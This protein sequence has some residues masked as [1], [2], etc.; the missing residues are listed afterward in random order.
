MRFHHAFV[1][2]VLC[3][4][5]ALPLSANTCPFGIL[6]PTPY[7][8]NDK[9]GDVTTG[10][11]N[12]D[13]YVDAAV[14]NRTTGQISILLGTAGG[15]FAAPTVIPTDYSQDDILAADFNHDGNLDLVF[16]V[17]W[18]NNFT[19]QPHLQMLIGHGDGTF[20]AQ[21]NQQEIFQNPSRMVLG[22][23]NKD[24]WIDVATT[25]ADGQWS[26]VQNVNGTLLQKAEY[27]TAG[28]IAAGIA[29][30]DFDGDGNL[31]I[32]ISEI[33]SKKV[34]L[35]FGIGDG[36]FTKSDNTIDLASA[37]GDP[38]D[39]EAGDFN[40]D[41]K[42]DLAIMIRK[43]SGALPNPGLK[44]SLSNGVA[45]TFTTPVDYGALRFPNELLVKDMDGD[46]K[47]D[48]L[49]ANAD[50]VALLRGNGDGTFAA[51]QAFGSGL[52]VGIAVDDFDRD[53]GPDILFTAFS[54]GQVDVLLNA[55]GRVNLTLTASPN[56]AA[57]GTAISVNASVVSPP[58]IAA[59][60][61]FTLK[62]GTTVL[63]SH[64]LNA[65]NMLAATMNNLSPGM[66]TLSAEYS[67]D[68]HFIA[69]IKTLNQVVTVPPFG[70]PPGL[71]ALSF[72]GPVQLAWIATADTDH[73]EVWRNN[74]AGWVFLAT[75]PNAAYTDSTAPATAALLYRVRAINGVGTASEYGAP[76]LALTYTF[77][78]GTLQPGV[79]RIKLAH[80]TE[81]RN[82][83][84]AVRAVAGLGAATWAD[85]SPLLIRASHI[86]ELRT[87]ID[88]ARAAIGLATLPYTNATLVVGSTPIKGAHFE[89]L[90]SAMR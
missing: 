81:L 22:D 50:G 19:V 12:K 66:Y 71:N 39:V 74:G 17:P 20:T 72:G 30:G 52:A 3:V 26:S 70:P 23:F 60:G 61:T 5:A 51:Q 13:G 75:S 78:D 83:A 76:D 58:A 36:T 4:F 65:G 11:F 21:P 41:G 49:A 35:F 44:I 45:R 82:A 85:S 27:T 8:A 15:G 80:L 9:A 69:A 10:D 59:T 87:A 90:R 46:G 33:V 28:G 84:N 62:R 56:P 86:A 2:A 7:P 47:L 34:Y 54:A 67:G 43:G 48:I 18:S 32:A 31:D 37:D 40:G 38:D 55:C 73:Y 68:S 1:P 25:K 42:D 6:S 64:N 53:G 77:T 24:G 29:V 16:A 88:Q 63:D 57:Q 79:T 89:E 14:L